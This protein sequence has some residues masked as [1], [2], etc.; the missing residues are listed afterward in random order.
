VKRIEDASLSQPGQHSLAYFYCLYRKGAQ[1]TLAAILQSFIAQ[2][3]PRTRVPAA[4][5]ELYELHNKKFPPGVPSDSELKETLLAII[6]NST[7][8]DGPPG[9]HSKIYFLI[10]ALDE[11]PVGSERDELLSYFAELASYAISHLHILM[12]SRDES[13]IRGVLVELRS[14]ENLSINRDRVSADMELYV[15]NEVEKHPRLS[16][17]S[18]EI[19]SQI[20]QRLVAEGNGM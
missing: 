10:D 19:K 11:W 8:L 1:H 16:Q 6:Q 2:L 9:E 7:S 20:M 12:T 13:D 4:L 17:K 15:A 14:W 5:R 18:P 3:C